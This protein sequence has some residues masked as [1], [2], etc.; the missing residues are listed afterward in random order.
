MKKT[1]LFLYACCLLTP[2][3]MQAQTLGRFTIQ[4]PKGMVGLQSAASINLDQFTFVHDSALSLVEVQGNKRVAVPFQ[5]KQEA[6]RWL[7]LQVP[8]GGPSKRHYEL[9]KAPGT[10]FPELVTHKDSGQITFLNGHQKL[11]NFYYKTVYPPA[12]IDTNYK[13]SGFIHP[14]Y[15]PNGQELTRI[16]APD[17]YHHYGIWNPWTHVYFDGDTV[18]FWNIKGRQGTVRFAQ[19]V[20]AANGPVFSEFKGLLEHVVFKKEGGEKV[21]LHELQTIRVYQPPAASRYYIVDITS[22]L[23]CATESPFHIL[24]YRY[25][26]MGWRTTGYWNN[27]NCTVLTSEGKNR[28]NTDGSKARWCIVQGALPGNDSGGVAFLSYPANYNHPEPMRIW[29][30][31]TNQR[32]DMFFNFAPTKDKDWLL[33]PGKTYQLRYRLIVFNGQLDA[34]TAESAWRNFAQPPVGY[35]VR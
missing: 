10:A 32:G 26:G 29:V 11:L 12:G 20:A 16:Q 15:T 4:Q 35:P 17:H 14:L 3:V 7:Y 23:N 30:K 24:A 34:A 2:V 19:L 18:D 9:I 27:D 33:L 1:S 5:V 13:R 6:N 8:A 31:N 22:E 25:A 21:A 28:D